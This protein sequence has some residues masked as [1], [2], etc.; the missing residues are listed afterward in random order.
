MQVLQDALLGCGAISGA[1][2]SLRRKK[3]ARRVDWNYSDDCE[4]NK[5]CASNRTALITIVGLRN[6][7]R[8]QRKR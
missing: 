3:N 1:S 4:N 7:A 8:P 6:P 2:G 5:W